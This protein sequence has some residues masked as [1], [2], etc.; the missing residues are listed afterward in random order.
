MFSPRNL[1]VVALVLFAL[2]VSVVGGVIFPFQPLQSAWQLRVSGSL[3]QAAP[4]PLL[5]LALLQLG[6]EL[7]PDDRILLRRWRRCSRLAVAAAVGFVLL[8]PLQ[9]LAGF[10]ESRALNRA[11]SSRISGAQHKLIM[12]R[13]AVASASSN[14]ELNQELQRRDGPVLG[15]ADLAQ[16]L[17]LLKA[18]VKAV[19]DQAE[20]QIRSERQR[21]PPIKAWSLLPDLLR[22]AFACLAL[23]L[24]FAAL[25]LRPGARR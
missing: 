20:I 3:I 7:N 22:N 5:G 21:V 9:G 17:P 4:L 11:Q 23:A 15:P 19:L 16:P 1:G 18:Q 2:F 8:L 6:L 24:G 14:A 13:E 12:L 25:G 10:N